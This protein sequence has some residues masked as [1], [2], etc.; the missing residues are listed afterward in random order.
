MCL[1]T[2]LPSLL[3]YSQMSASLHLVAVNILLCF[4][5]VNLLFKIHGWLSL[6]FEQSLSSVM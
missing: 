6:Y 3:V 2:F 1:P 5:I 4:P